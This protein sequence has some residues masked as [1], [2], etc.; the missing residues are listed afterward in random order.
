MKS[1]RTYKSSLAPHAGNEFGEHCLIWTETCCE[2]LNFLRSM[3]TSVFSNF[4]E[5]CIKG[6][7][8]CSYMFL[9][10]FIST[11]VWCKKLYYTHW[12][13]G[14]WETWWTDLV[15]IC[16]FD[17]HVS[18]RSCFTAGVD[19]KSNWRE[20][21]GVWHSQFLGSKPVLSWTFSDLFRVR[22]ETRTWALKALEVS[23]LIRPN[24]L[25]PKLLPG[26]LRLLEG[27]F[28]LLK[29]KWWGRIIRKDSLSHCVC[30][31]WPDVGKL[32]WANL[33]RIL[34]LWGIFLG[35]APLSL[36]GRDF[37]HPLWIL[38]NKKFRCKSEW[39]YRS[40]F[41]V[42]WVSPN[43]M[44]LR[45]ARRKRKTKAR[46]ALLHLSNFQVVD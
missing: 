4:M 27:S 2:N 38:A 33:L 36:G 43:D 13:R 25:S 16:N 28:R 21:E 10:L 7:L 9:N 17:W 23:C 20:L 19:S 12:N 40:Q 26:F 14:L 5:S 3:S 44:L 31:S 6:S 24:F 35:K 8:N 11:R 45:L 34:S 46:R 37:F 15:N 32:S 29:L 39:T 42:K 41:H 30:V 18:I 22:K 1:R